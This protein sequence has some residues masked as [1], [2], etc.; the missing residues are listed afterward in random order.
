M[1]FF[2]DVIICTELYGLNFKL[3]HLHVRGMLVS[4]GIS[5]RSVTMS[6]R[7]QTNSAQRVVGSLLK[8]IAINFLTGTV[9]P[10]R[11]KAEQVQG[12]HRWSGSSRARVGEDHTR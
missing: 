8:V 12:R 10:R 7:D 9:F 1:I 5:Q 6:L 2:N 4:G 11:Q 3:K